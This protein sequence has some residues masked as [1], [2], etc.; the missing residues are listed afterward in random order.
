MTGVQTCAL[1]IYIEYG[2]IKNSVNY[3]SVALPPSAANRICLMHSNI[4]GM[5]SKITDAFSA[6]GINIDNL[7]NGSKGEYA[8]TIV[9]AMADVPDSVISALGEIDGMIR[10]RKVEPV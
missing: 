5:L 1:P 6:S 2:N 4:A 9:E 10:V 8:Y 3:P 7:T